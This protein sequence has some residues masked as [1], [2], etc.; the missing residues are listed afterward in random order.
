MAKTKKRSASKLCALLMTTVLVAF[1]CSAAAF[2]AGPAPEAP[3][4]NTFAAEDVIIDGTEMDI[5]ESGT[6]YDIMPINEI[7]G[8]AIDE[9]ELDVVPIGEEVSTDSA[10]ADAD[11]AI[12]DEDVPTSDAD[13]EAI[14]DEDGAETTEAEPEVE[15]D[16]HA[17]NRFLILGGGAL[18]IC[19]GFYALLCVKTKKNKKK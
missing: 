12:P 2:A 9:V 18:A 11:E 8:E 7:D 15:E 16:N 14:D 4:I 19:I 3:E 13:A 1:S 5:V 17:R 10:P 6:E